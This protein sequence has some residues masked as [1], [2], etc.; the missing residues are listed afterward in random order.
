MDKLVEWGL[1]DIYGLIKRISL[2]SEPATEQDFML[3]N[4]V[5]LKFKMIDNEK[6]ILTGV[7]MRP[8]IKIKRLDENGELY[9]G[10]FSE[11]TVRKAS[12]YFFKKGS[13]LNYTNLEHKYEIDGVYVFESWIVEDP[14]LDKTKFLGFNDIVKGDWVVSMK[15]E[16]ENVWNNYLKTGLIRGFSVEI[17]L[18]EAE[19]NIYDKIIEILENKELNDEMRYDEITKLFQK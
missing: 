4:N 19:V 3:F 7:A 16:N 9:Y 13:N 11:E 14:E 17:K 15:V 12:E 1:D 18:N 6:R 8:N 2:V 5:D 10:F